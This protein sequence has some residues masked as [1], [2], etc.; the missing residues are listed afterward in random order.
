M[1]KTIIA[2]VISVAFILAQSGDL[3]MAQT[4]KK[5][6]DFALGDTKGILFDSKNVF[7]KKPV[8]IIFSTTWCPSCNKYLPLFKD[9]YAKYALMGLEIVSIDLNE[10]RDAVTAW[11]SSNKVPYRVLI[12]KDGSVGQK[13]GVMGV[14]TLVLIDKAGNIV[15]N[16]CGSLDLIEKVMKPKNRN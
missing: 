15:C 3:L 11:A 4:A 16:P 6:Y 5:P 14:P 2:L 10:T 1:K 12:D 9:V 13:Y 7:G 8:L